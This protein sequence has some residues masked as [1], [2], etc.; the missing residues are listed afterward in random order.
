[1]CTLDQVSS[2]FPPTVQHST[3]LPVRPVACLRAMS[4]SAVTFGRGSACPSCC[5]CQCARLSGSGPP[6]SCH[7]I[8]RCTFTH[9]VDSRP[10]T[11]MSILCVAESRRRLA[12]TARRGGVRASAARVVVAGAGSVC[13][14]AG[15][16]LAKRRGECRVRVKSHFHV[17]ESTGIVYTL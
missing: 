10:V 14:H 6:A 8:R 3:A 13:W 9:P 5:H 15:R 2:T 16:V 12:T 1:V 17:P 4:R 7:H 11:D